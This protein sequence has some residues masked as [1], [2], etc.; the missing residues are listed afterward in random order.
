M[1]TPDFVK[2][3]HNGASDAQAYRLTCSLY[4]CTDIFCAMFYL[5]VQATAVVIVV[6]EMT[7]GLFTLSSRPSNLFV[8]LTCSS[9]ADSAK[10]QIRS[11]W[12][13]SSSVGLDQRIVTLRWAWLVPG[14]VTVFGRVNYLGM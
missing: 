10:I 7:Y 11:G 3:S 1:L 13:F 14:W 5:F 12:W 6:S 4:L 9:A 8:V 2:L